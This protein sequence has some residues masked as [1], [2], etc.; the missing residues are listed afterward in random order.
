MEKCSNCE[1]NRNG[2]CIDKEVI[3]FSIYEYLVE[4]SI[5]RVHF[6]LILNYALKHGVAQSNC[7][8]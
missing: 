6:E 8:K 3:Y 2:L 5:D 7:I 1:H 4:N